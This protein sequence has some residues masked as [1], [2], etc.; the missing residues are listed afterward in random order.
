M[1]KTKFKVGDE[2]KVVKDSTG[3]GK[4]IGQKGGVIKL[5]ETGFGEPGCCVEFGGGLSLWFAYGEL[6]P[7]EES[8]NRFSYLH[9]ADNEPDCCQCLRFARDDAV[10]HCA[11]GCMVIHHELENRPFCAPD[12]RAA[13]KPAYPLKAGTPAEEPLPPSTP[14]HRLAVNPPHDHGFAPAEGPPPTTATTRTPRFCVGQRVQITNDTDKRVWRIFTYTWPFDGEYR[15]EPEGGP[16]G[17]SYVAESRLKPAEEP[18]VLKCP[19]AQSVRSY[20]EELKLGM[21]LPDGRL[22]S[23]TG[24]ILEPLAPAEEPQA[25]PQ[26]PTKATG[27][28]TMNEHEQWAANLRKPGMLLPTMK[29][30]RAKPFTCFAEPAQGYGG[31]DCMWVLMGFMTTPVYVGR[32]LFNELFEET[33]EDKEPSCPTSPLSHPI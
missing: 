7:A 9:I 18:S 12:S 22:M 15:I 11:L 8:A 1:S 23:M 2:V 17:E 29:E 25:I 20:A 6:A 19:N 30:Y 14:H 3:P 26:E 10:Y 31:T 28:E 13:C 16:N 27:E 32:E 24:E 33:S 21:P 5:G 4:M